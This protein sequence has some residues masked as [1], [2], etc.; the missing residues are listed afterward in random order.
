MTILRFRGKGLI[1]A[2]LA[3]LALSGCSTMEQDE[4][5]VGVQLFMYN[6]V[7][8]AKECEEVL[9]PAGINYA[10]IS[11]PQEH[12]TGDPWWVQYQPVSYQIES[13]LG[14]R[15][16]FEAM[17]K[18]CKD[19]GVGIIADAVINH[20]SASESGTGW[21][22]TEYSKYEYPG[23]YKSSDFHDCQLSENNQIQDYTNQEQV[24]TCEL[25][26]LSDLDTGSKKVQT[27]IADYLL[28]LLDIGVVGFR[29]DAAKHIWKENLATIIGQL[30]E[31]T[32]IYHEV[33]RGEGEPI[34]PEDYIFTGSVWEFSY[35]RETKDLFSY[36]AIEEVADLDRYDNFLPTE[37][38][39]SFITNHDT[40]RNGQTLNTFTEPREFELATA[41]MLADD[42]G[43]PMLYGGYAFQEYNEP[44]PLT[45]EGLVKNVKCED[46]SIRS[47]Y[48]PGSWPCQYRWK[49]TLG[50]VEFHKAVS[51]QPKTDIVQAP[52]LVA[53]GRGTAGFFAANA[54]M[55]TY[56]KPF[57]TQLEPG[58]YCDSISGGNKP[59]QSG[60]CLGLEIEVLENGSIEHDLESWSAFAIHE[61]A[62]LR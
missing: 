44:P 49:S 27:R 56:S 15:D 6:W 54:S 19:S 5:P 16:Q 29:I 37:S 10:F 34:Q 50:M 21:N 25:L 11:P 48:Q 35:A 40:E 38:A 42:Y 18:T 30:P 43:M 57:S 55:E 1:I 12:R 14:T 17:V 39:L 46:A 3:S 9:G 51:N 52:S 24:Q 22:G 13:R 33:I 61:K 58:I 7:S 32:L 47:D 8:V 2:L 4:S 26:G 28:D 45:A 23:L 20:M 59:V 53:W 41:I 60:E 31:Q 36:E 62:K